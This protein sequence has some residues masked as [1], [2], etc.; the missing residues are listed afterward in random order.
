MSP[1]GVAPPPAVPNGVIR[2]V[3]ADLRSTREARGKWPPGELSFSPSRTRDFERDPL[4]LLLRMYEE[5]GPVFAL[6]ILY[7]PMVFALGPEANHY[8]TVSNASNFR[9]RDGAMGDLIPLL[10]DGLLTTDGDY[11]KR[12]R[13]IMLPAFH[14]EQLAASTAIMVEEIRA[15]GGG[16]DAGLTTWIC[17]RGR[18]G[19]PC[20]SRCGR[21]SASHPTPAP[22]TPSWPT[23]SS[24]RS[25][26]GA[27]TTWCA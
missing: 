6:R 5:Y 11:H 20:A 7:L 18:G 15:G 19:S 2:R 3:R 17:M 27:R 12:A 8:M 21:C 14:R 22:A 24:T 23:S 1:M 13:R 9:W 4:P 16:S 25:A 10:G 26:I